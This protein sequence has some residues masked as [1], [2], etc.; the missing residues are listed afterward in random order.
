VDADVGGEDRPPELIGCM[1][2][3]RVQTAASAAHQASKPT[4]WKAVGAIPDGISADVRS[5]KLLKAVG[6]G[7]DGPTLYRGLDTSHAGNGEIRK[8]VDDSISYLENKLDPS[9]SA[10]GES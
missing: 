5:S 8:L 3:N 9:A 10:D 7:L 2:Q 1:P 6:H 4:V